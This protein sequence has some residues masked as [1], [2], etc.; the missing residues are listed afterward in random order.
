MSKMKYLYVLVSSEFDFY[1]EQAFLSVFSLK[2]YNPNAFVSFLMDTETE[3]YLRSCFENFFHF[4]DE[5]K[6]ISLSNKSNKEKSRILK[7]TMRNYID[8]DFL[9]IDCDTIV[10]EDLSSIANSNCDMA[11]VL[12]TH[13]SVDK[14]TFRNAIISNYKKCNFEVAVAENVHFNSGVIWC[15]DNERTR[16]FFNDWE[17]LWKK[18]SQHG[19]I[20]DQPSFNYAN[21]INNKMVNELTGDWN[22][23]LIHGGVKYLSSAKIIHYFSS[24][25]NKYG[26]PFIINNKSIFQEIKNSKLITPHL[27]DLLNN[28]RQL[29]ENNSTLL[30]D[31]VPRVLLYQAPM[32]ELVYL[33]KNHKKIYNFLRYIFCAVEKIHK[34]NGAL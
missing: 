2:K 11:C 7:T 15:K 8:G 28:P 34:I 24:I 14:H 31:D 16:N 13:V 22:C 6:V 1:A 12:D 32:R 3:N 21:V 4:I 5:V 30:G 23:Q 29:I 20:I 18:S 17:K 19:I 33:F 27:V 10:C 26:N 9:F 25:N